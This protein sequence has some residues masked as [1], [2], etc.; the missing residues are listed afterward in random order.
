LVADYAFQVNYFSYKTESKPANRNCNLEKEKSNMKS[1]WTLVIIVLLGFNLLSWGQSTNWKSVLL[2]GEHGE[3]SVEFNASEAVVDGNEDAFIAI[4][5]DNPSI[6]KIIVD[7]AYKGPWPMHINQGRFFV[8][9]NQLKQGKLYIM[10]FGLSPQSPWYAHL[11]GARGLPGNHVM[12]WRAFDISDLTKVTVTV[13]WENYTGAPTLINIGNPYGEGEY[14]FPGINYEALSQPILDEMGQYL[15]EDW[16]GRLVSIDT[17]AE[18][19]AADYATYAGASFADLF[20]Q[21]GGY[22]ADTQFVATGYFYT[23]KIDDKWWLVDPEGYPFWSQGVTGAGQGS[24]AHTLNR[25]SIFPTFED[26]IGSELWSEL[27]EQTTDNNINFYNMNLIR[28]YGADWEAKHEEV[29]VGRLKEWGLNSMGAWSRRLDSEKHPYTLIIHPQKQGIGNLTKLVDPFS[30]EFVQSLEGNLWTI[31]D[32]QNDPWLIGVFVNNELRWN[33]NNI[34]L[35]DEILALNNSI[36]ARQAMEDFLEEK[37][38]S[39]GN[40][41]AAWGSS[42]LSFTDIDGSASGA[43]FASD[44]DAYVDHFADTYFSIVSEKLE[45]FMPNHLYLGCRFYSG[46]FSN[47]PVL[48]AAS[49][50]CDVISINIYRHSIKDFNIETEEDKPWIIGEFHFGTG[51]HGVWGVGLTSASSLENQANL[52]KQ[53]IHEAANHPNFVGAHWFTWCDQPAVGRKDGENFRIGIVNVTDQSY[54]TLAQAISESSIEKYT[55]RLEED[56]ETT[57]SLNPQPNNIDKTIRVSPNPTQGRLEISLDQPY[58]K[59]HYFYLINA[60]GVVMQNGE[61]TDT[62]EVLDVSNLNPGIYLLHVR[63]EQKLMATRKVIIE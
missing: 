45:Q 11:S 37:Y 51:S 18:M 10:R 27:E 42:F 63:G 26:E 35:E 36:P 49:R 29:T 5:V 32:A 19:G 6:G 56:S 48:N 60:S 47:T 13:S 55:T 3:G 50:H 24:D 38:E 28:K 53:Y 43:T 9:P 44:M 57:S 8:E 33:D 17:L 30:D 21:Y 2:A 31:T 14:T 4:D 12:H 39:I 7:I 15:H 62:V 25:E 52:Y 1:K 61:F 16:D 58:S 40:L 22:K 41:N 34:L 46:T 59:R 54:G 20:S 23:T